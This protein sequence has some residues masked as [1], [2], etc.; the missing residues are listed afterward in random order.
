MIEYIS[1]LHLFLFSTFMQEP[2]RGDM[3]LNRKG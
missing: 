3:E 2:R 1:R